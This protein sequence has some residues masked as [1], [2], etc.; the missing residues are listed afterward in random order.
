MFTRHWELKVFFSSLQVPNPKPTEE[1]GIFC[2]DFTP[3]CWRELGPLPRVTSREK[4]CCIHEATG[5]CSALLSRVFLFHLILY[6]RATHLGFS[7]DSRVCWEILE[8]EFHLE[9]AP[10]QWSA[11]G[12]TQLLAH[13]AGW[14]PACR[15][16]VSALPWPFLSHSLSKIGT[17]LSQ[18]Q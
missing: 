2:A 18:R 14:H 10:L 6:F 13:S 5:P 17:G 11:C 1:Y 15:G 4:S 16:T 12:S 8:N 3:A 7:M 9:R